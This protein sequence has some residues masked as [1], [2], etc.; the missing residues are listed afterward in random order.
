[1]CLCLTSTCFSNLFLLPYFLHIAHSFCFEH[2]PC[3]LMPCAFYLFH[4]ET[5]VFLNLIDFSKVVPYITFPK[6]N[7]QT[8]KQNKN[9]QTKNIFVHSFHDKHFLLTPMIPFFSALVLI[10]WEDHY[11]LDEECGWKELKSKYFSS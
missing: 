7:K 1:M 4:L 6:T 5:L 11:L 10:A 8:K 2:V 3:S 9:K